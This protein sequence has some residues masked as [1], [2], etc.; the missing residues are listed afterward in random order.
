MPKILLL[1]H[2]K[3]HVGEHHES[4]PLWQF[5]LLKNDESRIV[6]YTKETRFSPLDTNI[7]N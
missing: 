6:K 2:P 4:L 7:I 3:S 5:W 1:D